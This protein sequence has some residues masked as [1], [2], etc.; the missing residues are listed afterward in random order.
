MLYRWLR[1]GKAFR[2]RR[3]SRGAADG[4]LASYRRLGLVVISVDSRV[5]L[6][7]DLGFATCLS[8]VGQFILFLYLGFLVS[9]WES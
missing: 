2:I 8:E 6:C 3:P 4:D 9:N 5:S 7:A 1:G